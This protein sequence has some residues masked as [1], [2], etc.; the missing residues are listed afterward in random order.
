MIHARTGRRPHHRAAPAGW[1]WL[2]K[3]ARKRRTLFRAQGL[4]ALGTV[5]REGVALGRERED[6]VAGLRDTDRVLELSREGLIAGDRGP[7]VVEN[8]GLGA[9]GVDHGLHREDHAGFQD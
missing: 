5:W 7:A 4:F 3:R 2:R 1:F 6:L 9:P 8:L